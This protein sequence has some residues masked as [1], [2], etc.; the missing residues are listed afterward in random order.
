[1]DAGFIECDARSCNARA[2]KEIWFDSGVS[3]HMCNHHAAEA[4]QDI[5]DAERFNLEP[6]VIMGCRM[7]A[8]A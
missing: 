6:S 4:I 3:L 8:N 1:M 5:P 7:K 2:Y